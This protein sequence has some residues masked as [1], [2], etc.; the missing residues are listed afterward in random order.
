MNTKLD[1]VLKKS[2]SF[3][4]IGFSSAL[5]CSA[6]AALVV[7]NGDFESEGGVAVSATGTSQLN[8]AL[9]NTSGN[10]DGWYYSEWSNPVTGGPAGSGDAYG[11]YSN[12]GRLRGAMNILT[13]NQNT[14]GSVTLSVDLI[15]SVGNDFKVKVWGIN[16]S[17]LVTPG[18]QWDGQF[19]LSGPTGNAD[20]LDLRNPGQDTAVAVSYTGDDITQLLSTTLIVTGSNWN[21]GNQ[22]TFDLGGTGYDQIAVGFV[23]SATGGTFGVDNLTVV[24]EPGSMALIGLGLGALLTRRRR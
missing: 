5:V 21:T 19:D 22:F 8:N 2:K 18:I 4:F 13:D 10:G 3:A 11:L 16:D 1:A 17:D 7:T 24:P 20:S 12:T 23:I 6:P 14:T 15:S 9:Y